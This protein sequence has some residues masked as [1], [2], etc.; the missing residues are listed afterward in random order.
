MTN[1]QAK[2]ILR[3]CGGHVQMIEGAP[4]WRAGLIVMDGVFSAEEL[5]AVLCFAEN[6]EVRA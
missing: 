4:D 6:E 2:A 1:D 3:D 5:R